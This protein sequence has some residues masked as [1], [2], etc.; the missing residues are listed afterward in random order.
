[1]NLNSQHEQVIALPRGGAESVLATHK[2]MRNTYAL[3]AMTL[4]FSAVTA[5]AA[6]G[7]QA[8]ASR[9]RADPGRLLRPAVR[10]P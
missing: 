8:A 3:L 1:M 6:A 5:G 10:R 9:H 7:A 4:L 2:V